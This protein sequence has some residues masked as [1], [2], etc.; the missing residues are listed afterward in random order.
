MRTYLLN[1]WDTVRTS[2]WFVPGLFAIGA[3]CLSLLVP[4]LDRHVDDSS[5]D[6]PKWIVTTVD[7]ARATLSALAGAM[8]AVT[9]TVFSITI[10]TL[11]LA[12]QQFGPRLL[13]RFMYDLPTQITLGVFLATGFYCLL[14]LRIVESHEDYK[15][16]MHLSVF[17][18]VLLA[19]LSMAMLIL[20]IHN[21]A[22]LIQ[23]PQVVAAVAHDLN[24][25]ID[26]LFPNPIGTSSDR[27]R[28]DPESQQAVLTGDSPDILSRHE[29]YIQAI[30]A[31]GLMH[32]AR[33]RDLLIK[34]LKRPGDFITVDTPL[35]QLATFDGKAYEDLDL[36]QI[37]HDL[38]EAVIVGIRR[39]PRQDVGCAINELVEVAVRALS[40]GINDPFTAMNCIDRLGAALGRL[41]ER[42]LPTAYRHDKDDRLRV[43]ARPVTFAEALGFV[44]HPIRQHSRDN[45]GVTLRLLETLKEIGSHVQ[46]DADWNA[47]VEMAEMVARHA[48]AV[49]E[50]NDRKLIRSQFEQIEK[51]Q[52]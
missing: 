40:P 43:I 19:V 31:E 45:V 52:I 18:A 20:F 10:V 51:P 2:F 46:R 44:F 39:T 23:A 12:S 17:A 16:P 36:D 24:D 21:V 11:S 3:V 34:L 28:N 1:L 41:A 35:V 38:N 6:L 26:R 4:W 33:E 22:V 13:R 32:I 8:V 50:E 48:A 27:E 25:S 14:V 47:V 37:S 9:G 7:S 49:P 15:E 5:Y 29:G 42:E 30:D